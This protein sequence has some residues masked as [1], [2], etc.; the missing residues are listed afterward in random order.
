M[1]KNSSLANREVFSK[2]DFND[3]S[4]LM[5][6]A[7]NGKVEGV[8]M[9]E[10]NDKIREVF[11]ELLGIDKDS[12]R[13]EIRRAMRRHKTELFEI[14]E[15]LVPELLLG[16]WGANPFFQDYVEVKSMNYGDT[17]VFI[18]PDESILTV[19]DV[20]GGHHDIIRQKLG[21]GKNYS[22]PTK[23]YAVKIY[24]EFELFLAGRV[25]WPGFIQKIYEAF[26]Y[27]VNTLVYAAFNGA[28]SA[29][30]P[31]AQFVK[32]GSLVSAT[33]LTLIEDVQ[34]ANP[35]KEIVI[36]GTKTALNKLNALA[37]ANWIS[38]A[39]KEERHTL[40]R[41]GWWQG[42]RLVEIPQAFAPN[43]TSTKLVA[44]DKLLIM[45]MD[46]ANKMIKVYDEG[47]AMI[48]EV[49]DGVTNMD[50]TMEYEY[51]QKMGVGVVFCRYFGVWSSIV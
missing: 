9:K 39:A 42:T 8:T 22:V 43:D 4:R 3:F 14:T 10:A 30:V 6:D 15:E 25:D 1:K 33:F 51:Q 26:D 29:I 31:S 50:M 36:M 40:G 7:A 13:Q 28:G 16:G 34:A 37:E 41:L 49:S 27:K 48:K 44:N 11:S 47:E 46:P 20:S 23:W 24:T 2:Y 12:T 18:V 21:K 32:S 45:P 17:N 38:E 19:S 35:G 5:F